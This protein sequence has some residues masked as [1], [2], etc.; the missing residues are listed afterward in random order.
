MMDRVHREE[1][2]FSK[3][4]KRCLARGYKKAEDNHLEEIFS[5]DCFLLT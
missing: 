4:F 3:L 5:V 1:L 2:Q